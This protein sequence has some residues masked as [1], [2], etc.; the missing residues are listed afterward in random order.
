M[1]ETSGM[2][3]GSVPERPVVSVP[4]RRSI[5]RNVVSLL[6]GQVGT[7]AISN[8]ISAIIGRVHGPASLRLHNLVMAS[9]NLAGI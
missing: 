5:A 4:P 7:M 9:I 1:S 3:V 2:V 8:V 6:L